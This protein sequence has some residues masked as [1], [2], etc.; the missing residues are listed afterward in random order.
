MFKNYFKVA[1][2]SLVKQKVYTFINV[3]GL[4]VG[5]ASCLLITM[6]VV[7]EF[8][9]D[10]FHKDAAN[11]YKIVLERKYPN[12]VTNYAVIPHSY[13]DVIVQDFPE[14][15]QTVKMAG[16]INNVL[17]NYANEQQEVKQFEENFI[18][19]ADS[20][21]FDVF[22][23][24]LL[25]GDPK[26]VLIK[27]T[28]MVV[29]EETARRYFGDSPA[30]GKTLRIFNQDFSITGVCENVPE[31]SHFKFD[32]LGKWTDEFFA[33][34]LRT[35]FTTFSAH[36]Y[37]VLKPGADPK[38]LEAKFPAM[39]DNYA[40]AQ[41][42]QDL[43]KSW[44]DYKKEG[45]GYRYFLQPLTSIHLD[46]LNVEAKMRPGGNINYVYFLISIA[47]LI[48]VIA[49]INF[50]NLATARSAERAREVGVRKTMGSLK[51]QLISQFLVES[52]LISLIA[53]GLAIGF[54]QIALPYFNDLAGKNLTFT[55]SP[56]FV[57]G[58]LGVALF[59]GFMAG[60]YPAFAL[61]S[62][63]PILVMKGNFSG[64]SKGSWLRNGLVVFQF[65]ISI[66]L[67]VGT[68][69]VSRQMKFM[70]NKSLGYDKEQIV[71]IERA[72]ALA[73]QTQTFVDE[74]KRIPGVERASSSFSL[75]GRQGDFF[76]AQFIP[77]GS[78]EILTTKSMGIDDGFAETI[79]FEF[80]VGHGY[81]EETN[82]SLSI[83]LNET[84]VKTMEIKDPIGKKLKQI[85]RTPQGSVEV[86]YTIIGVIKDFNFQSLR[87]PITPLTIQSVE[88]FGGGAAYVVARVKGSEL[89]TIVDEIEAKWKALVPEQLFKFV[90]L[91]QNLMAQYE[92]EKR[93]GQ[94]FAIFS[95]LAII[96]ACVG[97]FGLS[98]YTAS[99]RTKEIGVRK[100]MGASV[101]SIV[102]LLS[103]EFTK[104]ILVAFVLSVPI[105]W[106][107]MSQW[108]SGF[109]YRIQLGVGI[110]LLAGVVALLI[111]WITVSYQSIKAAIVNPIK[112]LRSE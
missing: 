72:F 60:S 11:I 54:A 74:V 14:V 1:F 84:A 91:D 43:G 83:I 111:S 15:Q 102:L 42:E 79:G 66:V 32:F 88:S 59:V 34:G 19:A 80:I 97:L 104:L 67:I 40:A 89:T 77:E 4:S 71:V 75:L 10:K 112:S 98:A 31:N 61:S 49:C 96:I 65:F 108:L 76:G 95:S 16:A 69:V 17:V 48:L 73:E 8:S 28:D 109:A 7:D 20:N 46:P 85:Q 3:L 110:Y 70:H 93:A 9:Y 5:I 30:I 68:M 78:S 52:I 99:L 26:K 50:M 27:P 87:D 106:Y 82:D 47:I 51:G 86:F 103:K 100:V 21:F 23:I 105:S 53:T 12:H 58:L 57:G 44:E 64:N 94:V 6:F 62:I 33:G 37:L 63:Q 56:L 18:M 55:F 39:V 24:K 90:F 107:L 35:N 2:R 41:I 22:S 81:S 101:G 36:V 13:A 25:Q 38:A 29:T 92:S 45:N